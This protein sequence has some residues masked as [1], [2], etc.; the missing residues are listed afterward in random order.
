MTLE[1]DPEGFESKSLHKFADFADKRVLEI[2]CG[3][4]RLTRKYAAPSSLT[5]GID[6]DHDALR[7]ARTDSPYTLQKL[8]HFAEASATHIPFAYE[9]FDIAILAWSL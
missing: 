9:T 6:P 5:I 2:G 8:V 1:R 3:E 7:I 4:G